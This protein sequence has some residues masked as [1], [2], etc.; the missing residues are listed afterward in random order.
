MRKK[1]KIVIIVYIRKDLEPFLAES[2]LRASHYSDTR[3]IF[4]VVRE[5]NCWSFAAVRLRVRNGKKIESNA[6]N[7]CG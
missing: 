5:N 7:H 3:A 4:S 6:L 1:S 2:T